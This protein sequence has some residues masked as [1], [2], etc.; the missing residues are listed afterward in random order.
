MDAFSS[1]TEYAADLSFAWSNSV[2][3]TILNRT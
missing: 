3:T 1:A 2:A